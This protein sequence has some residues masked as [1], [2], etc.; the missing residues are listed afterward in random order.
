MDLEELIDYISTE[1]PDATMFV[2]PNFYEAIVGYTENDEGLPVFVYDYNKMI[3]SLA[4]EYEDSEDPVTDAIEWIE[5][6][7]MRTLPY[8]GNSRPVIIYT[9]L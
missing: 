9:I 4:E 3:E 2:N 1:N 8:M 5:Y 6:N 7:T